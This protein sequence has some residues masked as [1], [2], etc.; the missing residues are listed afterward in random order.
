MLNEEESKH[1]VRVLR[2]KSGDRVSL[3]DG[4]GNLSEAIIQSADSKNLSLQIINTI[5]EYQKRNYRL[6]IAMAPTKNID[7]FEW[8]LEKATEIG[9]D[10]ISPIVTD[11]SERRKIRTDR[12]DKIIVAAMKQSVKAYKPIL[13]PIISFN[14][15]MKKHHNETELFIA[16]CHE[17]EK[18]DLKNSYHPGK[19]TIVMVGPEGDFSGHE[20]KRAL[21]TNFKPVT[22]G[23]SRLRTET[24]GIVICHTIYFLNR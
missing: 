24:A 7:R 4:K 23:A 13:N 19:H 3:T 9:I 1:C 6:H 5:N 16:H 15:F 18:L 20:I 22:M 21:N 17:K 11:H 8:F 2:L 14:D 10:E 12:L